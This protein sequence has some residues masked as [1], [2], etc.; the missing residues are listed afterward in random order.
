MMN[1]YNKWKVI[2]ETDFVILFIKTW[3][4]YVVLQLM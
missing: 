2:T 3:F 4:T 1:T